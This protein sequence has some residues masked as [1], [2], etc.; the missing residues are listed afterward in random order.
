MAT[1]LSAA[2]FFDDARRHEFF[3]N[4]WYGNFRLFINPR[5][6]V[7][8]FTSSDRQQILGRLRFKP[9]EPSISA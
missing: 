3:L 5:S 6:K 9:D 8:K 7:G 4:L 1:E 2:G